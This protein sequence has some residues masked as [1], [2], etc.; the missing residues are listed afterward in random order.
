ME[1]RNKDS[2]E[3]CHRTGNMRN[4]NSVVDLLVEDQ[5]LVKDEDHVEVVSPPDKLFALRSICMVYIGQ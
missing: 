5:G 3:Y 2:I 1:H 4:N